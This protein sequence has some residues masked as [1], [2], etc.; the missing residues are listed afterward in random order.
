M[1]TISYNQF[2]NNLNH[3]RTQIEAACRKVSRSPDEV[4]IMAVT[5][6]FPED[7]VHIARKAGMTL[8]GENRV[9]EALKKYKDSESDIELHLIGHLQRNKAKPAAELFCC[10]QSIDKYETALVLDKYAEELGKTIILFIEINTSSE[11]TKFG[12]REIDRYWKMVDSIL[13]L[14]NLEFRGLMTVGPFTDNKETVRKSFSSLR[15]LFRQTKDRY[16]G[17]SLDVLSMGMTSDYDIAVEEG[18]TM[19]RIG[20]A[21]FGE[22]NYR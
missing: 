22:R 5:K 3:I 2:L 4:R 16:P 17:L 21:L 12:I 10:V 20:T 19:V 7:Y 6:S 15:E 18:S 11:Q 13:L 9:Q 8:F 1:Q 14:K